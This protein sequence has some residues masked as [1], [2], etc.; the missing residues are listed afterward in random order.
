MAS[1]SQP[2]Q[3]HHEPGLGVDRHL[4][5]VAAAVTTAHQDGL[6]AQGD[7]A[8]VAGLEVTLDRLAKEQTYYAARCSVKDAPPPTTSVVA[9]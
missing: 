6:V 8:L 1:S 3:L 2:R 7:E 5:Q 9:R 4:R